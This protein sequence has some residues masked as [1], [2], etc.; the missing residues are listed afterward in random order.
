MPA[1]YG[2]LKSKG[3]PL[4]ELALLKRSIVEVKTEQNCLAHALVI[5]IAKRETTPIIKRIGKAGKLYLSSNTCWR[6]QGLT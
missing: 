2:G 6:R 4:S 5:A 1:G 3:R